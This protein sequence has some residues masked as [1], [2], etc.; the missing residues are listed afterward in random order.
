MN[1]FLVEYREFVVFFILHNKPNTILLISQQQCIRLRPFCVKCN[2]IFPN[3]GLFHYDIFQ[4]TIPAKLIF[5]QLILKCRIQV[6]KIALMSCFLAPL[7]SQP[8]KTIIT[9]H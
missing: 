3:W 1:P 7:W 6:G 8:L 4:T 5:G 2:L 9:Y